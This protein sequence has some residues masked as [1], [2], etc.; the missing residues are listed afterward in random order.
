MTAATNLCVLVVD[1]DDDAR[2]LLRAVLETHVSEVLMAESAAVAISL[3]EQQRPHVLVSDIAMPDEDGYALIRRVRA[4]PPD[5]GGDTPAIAVTAYSG[6][7]D[8]QK[9]LAAGFN[10]HMAKPVD[11]ESFVAAVQELGTA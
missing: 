5:R 6:G 4:L 8:R 2:E 3:L 10:R 1:D 7:A 9:A 11:L